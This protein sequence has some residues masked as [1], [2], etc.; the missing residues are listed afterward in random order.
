MN[1]EV[2]KNKI[3]WFSLE[4]FR[5][6]RKLL[7]I[8]RDSENIFSGISYFYSHQFGDGRSNEYQFEK[9]FKSYALQ[10]NA[11]FTPQKRFDFCINADN[12]SEVKTPEEIKSFLCDWKEEYELI[13]YMN[14][15][16]VASHPILENLRGHYNASVRVFHC[17]RLMTSRIQML[18]GKEVVVIAELI[19][20]DQLPSPDQVDGD[21]PTLDPSLGERAVLIKNHMGDWAVVIGSWIGYRRAKEGK[22]FERCIINNKGENIVQRYTLPIRQETR[23]DLQYRI[24]RLPSCQKST[25]LP[26]HLKVNFYT[27]DIQMFDHLEEAAENIGLVFSV[28]LLH[29]LCKPRKRDWKEGDQDNQS[30]HN[31]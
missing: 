18:C 8:S 3:C 27:G 10:V 1:F 12:F 23:G 15:T 29:V 21:I 16:C 28:A 24:Y 20:T 5:S 30:T 9:A 2:V 6:K 31:P 17:A 19:S 14:E 26:E 4:I 25:S 11:W 22:T 7:C 13:P